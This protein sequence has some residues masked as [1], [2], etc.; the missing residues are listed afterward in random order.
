MSFPPHPIS[1]KQRAANRANAQHSTGPRTSDGKARSA[2]NARKHGFTASTFAVV[3]LEALDELAHLKADLIAVYQPVNSQELFAVE[4][5][6]LTQQTLLRGAR[7]EAGLFTSAL[8]LTLCGEEPFITMPAEL[9]GNGDIEITRA[10]NRNFA[11]GEG[12][13]RLARKSNCWSL[14]L[15]YQAQSERMY[16]R[17]VEEF[18]RLKRLRH[19]LPNEPIFEPEPEENK[20]VV[21]PETNPFPSPAAPP[22]APPAP[23]AATAP[24][25]DLQPPDLVIPIEPPASLPARPDGDLPSCEPVPG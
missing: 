15:R 12:F 10:Q 4:R 23:E 3:R 13:H 17:A 18:E 19:E 16:R 22:E 24:T 7:L 25:E 21:G 11:L 1:D 9:A 20:A 5:I 8:S 14:F 6:A 2:Q